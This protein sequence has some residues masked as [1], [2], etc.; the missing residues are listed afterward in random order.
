MG[1]N[2]PVHVCRLI[3]GRVLRQ[4]FQDVQRERQ[5][6]A[7]RGWRLMRKMTCAPR[8]CVR[9]GSRSRTW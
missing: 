5:H 1:L 6:D 9:I 7:A 3:R 8:Y 2:D 4:A